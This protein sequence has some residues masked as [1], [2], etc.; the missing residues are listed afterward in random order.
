MNL[1]SALDNLIEEHSNLSRKVG[2]IEAMVSSL[3]INTPG[4][5]NTYLIL[6]DELFRIEMELTK[7]KEELR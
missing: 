2:K 6:G 7:L 3:R 1:H 4:R 5:E